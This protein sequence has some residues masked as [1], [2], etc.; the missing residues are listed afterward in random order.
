MG[1]LNHSNISF[2]EVMSRVNKKVAHFFY[3][4]LFNTNWEVIFLPFLKENRTSLPNS[5]SGHTSYSISTAVWHTRVK[6]GYESFHLI[7]MGKNGLWRSCN[8]KHNMWDKIKWYIKS[9]FHRNCVNFSVLL[10]L[11]L[12]HN[13]TE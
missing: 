13:I 7:L 8:K 5:W 9:L 6:I 2:F 4:T 12:T 11:L 10:N 3:T 1:I